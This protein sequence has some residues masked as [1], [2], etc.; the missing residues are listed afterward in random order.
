M[1]TQ[2]FN[3]ILRMQ[4]KVNLVLFLMIVIC[5]IQR[6]IVLYVTVSYL[7]K[8]LIGCTKCFVLCAYTRFTL[9]F[10]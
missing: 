5:D 2:V 8:K 3:N 9:E 10:A 7:A 6:R 1:L 4:K